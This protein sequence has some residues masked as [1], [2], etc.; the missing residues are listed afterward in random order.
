M[1]ER[2]CPLFFL[3][4]HFF[5]ASAF[6]DDASS[7]CA[8]IRTPNDLLLCVRSRHPEIGRSDALAEQA[9]E[10]QN[11]ARKWANP[12]FS[13]RNIFVSNSSQS[14]P[15]N[16][17]NLS[18]NL[19]I[20]G[21]RGARLQRAK[22]SFSV[23]LSDRQ[24][25]GEKLTLQTVTSLYRIRQIRDELKL[26]DEATETFRNLQVQ[27]RRRGRLTPDQAVSLDVLQMAEKDYSHRKIELQ[28]EE[29]TLIHFF[30][31]AVDPDFSLPSSALPAQKLHWPTLGRPLIVAG[32]GDSQ[33]A[34]AELEV[35]KADV[36][37]QKATRW[38]DLKLGP[39]MQIQSEGSSRN[40]FLGFN[41]SFSIP[42]WNWNSAQVRAAELGLSAADQK[43][44][45]VRT[46]AE[47]EWEERFEIYNRCVSAMA[48][49]SPDK[50]M[51][52]RHRSLHGYIARG[53]V[54]AALVTELHRQLFDFTV[55][56]HHNELKAAESLWTIFVIEGRALAEKLE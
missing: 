27:Y 21:R 2:L 35:S 31:V 1:L 28:N 4:V 23:R 32:G 47:E 44:R 34:I 17:L 11:A 16:E 55:S 29:E 38:P 30:H 6:S 41:V 8:S 33:R 49:D 36:E 50:K 19:E 52:D 40:S 46:S 5:I 43:M 54:N 42:I 45:F 14:V 51:D 48:K 37:F 9:A 39:S 56:F 13:F 12:E 26:L 15:E 25:L 24:L 10:D 7:P 53:L 20:G 18:Q 22:A 3:T